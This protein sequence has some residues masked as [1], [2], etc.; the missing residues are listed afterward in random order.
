MNKLSHQQLTLGEVLAKVSQKIT[1]S[2]FYLVSEEVFSEE[3]RITWFRLNIVRVL[4]SL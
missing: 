3:I 4:V 2:L 1:L